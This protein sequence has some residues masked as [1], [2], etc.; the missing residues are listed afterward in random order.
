MSRF[1][2]A[3]VHE[4]SFCTVYNKVSCAIVA[5]GGKGHHGMVG[6]VNM[7]WGKYEI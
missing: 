6:G 5:F 4:K 2:R 7:K 1:L 3:F